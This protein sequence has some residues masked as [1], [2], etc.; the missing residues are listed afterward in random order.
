MK[1]LSFLLLLFL[2]FVAVA[3]QRSSFT[4]GLQ[5][6]DTD[7]KQIN[8]HG[9]CVV[10][11]E[12]QYYWLGEDRTGSVSNGISCYQSSD[13]YNWKRLGLAMSAGGEMREDMNDVAQ[14]RLFERPK[15]VFN[16]KTGKWVL[17]AHWESGKDYSEA[18]VCVVTSDK[19]EGPYIL[20][21]TFRPNNHD[22]RDQTLFKDLD[23]KVYH[24]GSTDMNTNMNVAL[25]RDDC[26]EP[27]STETKILNGEK[28]EAPAIFR[29]GNR[30]FGL[31]SG[32]TGWA[33]N[34][35]R[36]AYTDN[37]LKPWHYEG[38]NFAVDERKDLTYQSQSNYVLKV[39]SRENAYIY[40]GDRWNPKNVG[41]SHYVW[42][43]VSMRSGFPVVKWYDTWDL[44]VFDKMYRYRRAKEIVQGNMY[45]LLEKCSDRLVSKSSNGFM[46]AD[47]NDEINLNFEFIATENP[48]VFKLKDVKTG[49]F[50]DS[51]F[52]ALSLNVESK[53]ESQNWSFTPKIDGYYMIQNM[54]EKKY[55]TVSGSSTLNGTNLYLSDKTKNLMQEFAVYFDSEKYDYKESDLF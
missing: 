38:R 36:M 28:C 48:N 49:K 20:Y 22:S 16:E 34:A 42:L 14:G 52:G 31:F 9:G 19:V 55:I 2:P 54:K 29:V 44:S 13:L 1:K 26:L 11:H 10:F 3:Q 45:S 8:A 18:R 30:Y 23:G 15:V 24:F 41:G 40:M 4:P 53:S 12:G 32:C 39:E 37:L 51:M 35:G 5:W 21:K 27:T 50:L 47:D 7:G 6:N 33:P 17:W 43:P 46:I 25:L